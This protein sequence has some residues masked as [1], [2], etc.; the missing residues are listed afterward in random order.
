MGGRVI[1]SGGLSMK[2]IC[3]TNSFTNTC[4]NVQRSIPAK[5]VLPHLEGVLIETTDENT[6]KLTGFDLDIAVMTTVNVRVEEPGAA[7]LNA[8]IFCDMLRRL[9]EKN[10]TITCNEK[11]ICT[12]SSGESEYTLISLNPA[13]YPELPVITEEQSFSLN[14]GILKDMIKR[15]VFAVSADDGKTVHRGVKN[16]VRSGEIKLVALDGYRL[17][18]RNEFTDYNGTDLMFVV[19]AKTLYEIIKLAENDEDVIEISKGRRHIKFSV[20]GYCLISKL[21]E[22]EFLDYR[23]AFPKGKTST[24]RVNTKKFMDIIERTSPVITEKARSPIKFIFEDDELNLSTF[25]ALGSFTEKLPVSIDGVRTEIGFNNRF[26]LDALRSC[27]T[28]EVL[29]ELNGSLS[30]AV[31]VPP[32]GESFLYLILPVR[33]KND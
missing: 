29:I 22:G 21:L 4:L 33:I 8:K 27:D 18:I 23:S 3:E 7:V 10:V 31:I 13:E 15:T 20:N 30:P 26:L 2:I 9:P 25:T 12:I 1:F 14:A 28:D 32:E 6:V 19:P 5:A 17:A 16:E 24:V 11:N